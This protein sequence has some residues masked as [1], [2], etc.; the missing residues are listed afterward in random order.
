[1]KVV[2]IATSGDPQ[3]LEVQEV[4]NPEI[5]DDEVLIRVDAAAINR[6]DTLQRKGLHPPSKAAFPTPVSNVLESSKLLERSLWYTDVWSSFLWYTVCGG[7]YAEKV[8]VPVGQVP[9]VPSGVSLKDAAGIPEV[10]YPVHG[11]SIGIGAF[12]IQIAKYRGARIFVTAADVCVNYKTEDFVAWVE[13]TGGKDIDSLNVDGRLFIIGFQGG[14]VAEV[15]LS[16]LLA[17][18][19]TVQVR[20]RRMFGLQSQAYK[21]F[22]LTEAVED[23]QL[24][25]S[26]KHIEKIPLIPLCYGYE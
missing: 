16:G 26:S 3:V 25:E 24:M 8:A 5:G 13:E 15:N 19:L 2:V 4:E 17:R 23:H 6:V 11:S 21:Y 22:P 14:T 1:M 12:A 18:R 9:L 10:A 20:W 7:G